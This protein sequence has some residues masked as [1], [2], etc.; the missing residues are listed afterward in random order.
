MFLPSTKFDVKKYIAWSEDD[1]TPCI[2]LMLVQ[3]IS[4]AVNGTT[5]ALH[6]V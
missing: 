2:A 6:S 5:L 1:R 4:T 3:L